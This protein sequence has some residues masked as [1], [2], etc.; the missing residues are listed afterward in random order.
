MHGL[1]QRLVKLLHGTLRIEF[2][3]VLVLVFESALQQEILEKL[4][5][6]LRGEALERITTELRVFDEFHGTTFLDRVSSTAGIPAVLF[7]AGKQDSIEAA[8]P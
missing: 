7:A 5:E 4:Q 1:K 2:I 8:T 3:E 6:V